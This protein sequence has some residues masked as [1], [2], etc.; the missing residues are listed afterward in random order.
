M[1]SVDI[2][3][4]KLCNRS[5]FNV[6]LF[7]TSCILRKI[8]PSQHKGSSHEWLR[9]QLNDEYVKK[10]RYDRYRCR[11]AY[12]LLEIDERFNILKQGATVVDCGAA[13]GSWTQVV[14]RKLKLNT[15]NGHQNGLVIAIDLQHIDHI[16]G[17]IIL[18]ES[19]FMDSDVQE[20][21]YKLLP[22]G[23]AD[24]V[25]S[26]MAPRASGN[27]E[28]DAASIMTLVYC[29]LKFSM[30]TLKNGGTFLCKV[31]DNN[32]VE[33]IVN[34]LNSLFSS[35]KRV[36]P[37]ACRSDSSELYLLARGFKNNQI[38]TT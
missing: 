16:K 15:D 2:N 21:V 14:T 29:A 25:L 18:K 34:A 37:K 6:R 38:K 33:K 27:T 32:D 3:I 35:V 30:R 1:V 24:V 20:K 9:R 5:F 13:P 22:N 31:W 28:L 8:V 17:A 11:S 7:Y 12:K 36:K 26:D 4:L 10:C 23:Q 19:N